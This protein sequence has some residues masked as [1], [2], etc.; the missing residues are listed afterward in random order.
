MFRTG[1][2]KRNLIKGYQ[3]NRGIKVE[4]KIFKVYKEKRK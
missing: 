3:N 1:Q 4:L 2:G